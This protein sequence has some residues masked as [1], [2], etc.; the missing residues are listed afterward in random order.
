M[1]VGGPPTIWPGGHRAVLCLTFDVDGPYGEANYRGDDQYWISQTAYDPAGTNRILNLLA[2][3]D[4]QA[5]FCWVGRAAEDHPYLVKRAAS[6]GHEIALHSW[7]HRYYNRLSEDEQRADMTRTFETLT[8][9]TGVAATGHKT[10]SWRY[11]DATHAIAQEIGLMWVMDEPGG[12]QPYLLQPDPAR[13]PLVQLPP[14]WLW[15]DYT[16]F[17]D[18]LLTPDQTF[19]C[20]RDDLDVLR[21]EGGVMCLTL[22]PFVSGRPGPSRAVARLIDYAVDLGDIWI[23][24]ADDIARW[25]LERTRGPER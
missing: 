18:R 11:D 22:H 24:R 25:W 8:R 19:A 7:D 13:D 21:D 3:T 10:A 5:T 12:D 23:A 4:V 9:M 1:S 2:D 14:S 16:F 20:W 15:D 6:E 17:V